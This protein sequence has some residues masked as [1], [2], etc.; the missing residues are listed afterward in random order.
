M[1]PKVIVFLVSLI[2]ACAS[3]ERPHPE[4]RLYGDISSRVIGGSEAPLGSYPHIVSLQYINNR[5]KHFCAGSILNN[6]W[7]ITAAHCLE[8]KT[9]DNFVV[10]A[11]KH[12]IEIVESTE[13]TVQ[14]EQIV[15][16]EKYSKLNGIPVYDIGLIKL[17]TPLKFTKEIQAIELPQAESEPTGIAYFCGWGSILSN[18]VYPD[19]YPDKLQHVKLNYIKRESCKIFIRLL[20]G[21]SL[22]ETN[23]CT[24]SLS[25][26]SIC[27][28]DSG[29]PLITRYGQKSVLTGIASWG[30]WPCGE[31]YAPSVYT[32]VSKFNA[33]IEQKIANHTTRL[34]GYINE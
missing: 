11:G 31:L 25:G 13:Q 24:G 8:N 33:W 10:K 3:V 6:Q 17:K 15:I 9:I 29:G 7:I 18:D 2:M 12:N 16:H 14:V 20:L 4:I 32:K 28:G 5:I 26:I 22:H 1:S 30:F 21:S 27:F 19:V 34:Y 23:I